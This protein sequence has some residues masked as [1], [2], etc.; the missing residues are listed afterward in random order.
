M[1]LFPNKKGKKYDTGKLTRHMKA[2]VGL[3]LGDIK[4]SGICYYYQFLINNRY[5]EWDATSITAAFSGD[6]ERKIKDHIRGC[7]Q[8]PG[9]GCRVRRAS[10]VNYTGP[11]SV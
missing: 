4:N 3:T 5:L 10:M 2:V 9:D 7:G 6:Q 8:P 1:H 11:P